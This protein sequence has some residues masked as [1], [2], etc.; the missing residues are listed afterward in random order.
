MTSKTVVVHS[1][2]FL[3]SSSQSGVPFCLPPTL[4]TYALLNTPGTISNY[5]L[6]SVPP[7]TYQKLGEG[8]TS[9]RNHDLMD[10]KS[11]FLSCSASRVSQNQQRS[12]FDLLCSNHHLWVLNLPLSVCYRFASTDG[13]SVQFHQSVSRSVVP[14]MPMKFII[15]SIV[16]EGRICPP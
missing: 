16:S 14:N 12:S 3:V 5:A 2:Y 1:T 7:N 15:V 6:T 4:D 9:L 10:M 13:A 11:I 8:E